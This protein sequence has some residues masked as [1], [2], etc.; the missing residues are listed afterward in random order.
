MNPGDAASRIVG[1]YAIF[2]AIA[3]GGMASVHFGRLIGP[4][5][6]SR[7]VAIKRLHE[8]LAQD[9]EF[10]EMFMDEAR[11]AARIRHPNVVPTLDI[12]AL[13]QELLLVMEYVPGE[14][15]ALLLKRARLARKPAPIPIV[16]AVIMEALHGLHAAHEAVGEAGEPL[17]IVHR[18]VSP[19]NILVGT[20]GVARVLDFG[21][22]KAIGMSHQTRAGQIKGKIRYMAPEQLRGRGDVTRAA[23]IYAASIVFWEA[24]TGERL[25]KGENDAEIMYQVLHGR[26]DPPSRLRPEVPRA[27][28]EIVM[29]GLRPEASDRYATAQAMAIALEGAVPLVGRSTVAAWVQENASDAIQRR[30]ERLAFVESTGIRAL[31]ARSQPDRMESAPA[32][33]EGSFPRASTVPAARGESSEVVSSLTPPSVERSVRVTAPPGWRERRG[34]LAGLA[35]VAVVSLAPIFLSV[36]R[37]PHPAAASQISPLPPADPPP[38]V[39]MLLP[40][41]PSAA[42]APP[43][44]M[45]PALAA[46]PPLPVV[47]QLAIAAPSA[48]API[49]APR[50]RAPTPSAAKPAPPKGPTLDRPDRLYRRD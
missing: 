31:L 1:R 27:V 7:T 15:L 3:S 33:S 20:D 49:E 12:V 2:D 11:V 22:A 30:K 36:S 39:T 18:D 32:R 16:V 24:L 50:K 10:V 40:D 35:A 43:E 6:F 47:Q 37:A 5:G 19:Q 45:K 42:I 9:P 21:V 28:D 4:A 23:D 41:P 38:P 48:S 46:A 14:S 44:P 29:R 8:S 25:F 13:E 34:V 26:V 17:G